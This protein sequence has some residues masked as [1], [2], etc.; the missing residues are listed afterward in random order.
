MKNKLGHNFVE[1]TDKIS[2]YNNKHRKN[3]YVSVYDLICTEC[4]LIVNSKLTLIIT[5]TG[6]IPFNISCDDYIIKKILE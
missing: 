2:L 6:G 1:I 4:E 3:I 5:S